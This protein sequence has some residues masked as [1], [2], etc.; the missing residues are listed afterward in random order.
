[1][2][3]GEDEVCSFFSPFP[4]VWVHDSQMGC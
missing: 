2:R 1:M 4:D 3:G